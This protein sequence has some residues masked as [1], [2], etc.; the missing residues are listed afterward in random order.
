MLSRIFARSSFLPI[1]RQVG[2]NGARPSLADLV[3]TL[4][5]LR[6]A[7]LEKPRVR[8]ALGRSPFM[9]R[10]VWGTIRV[11]QAFTRLVRRQETFQTN[12]GL[13]FQ[14]VPRRLQIACRPSDW[15]WSICLGAVGPTSARPDVVDRSLC[16]WGLSGSFLGLEFCSPLTFKGRCSSGRQSHMALSA[17][18][19]AGVATLSSRCMTSTPLESTISE[20]MCGS[21]PARSFNHPV[22]QDGT[23]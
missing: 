1:W 6:P 8:P 14:G 9:A 21:R 23:Q 20:P 17:F 7:V 2:T 3:G 19:F 16:K 11:A 10:S 4:R 15:V 13:A 12:R 5:T 18:C 22:V